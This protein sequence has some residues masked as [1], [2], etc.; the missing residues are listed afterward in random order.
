MTPAPRP[1]LDLSVSVAG[2]ELKN[3]VIAASGTF[4]Y[5]VEF[6]DIVALSRMGG[7]VVRELGWRRLLAIGKPRPKQFLKFDV[8]LSRRIGKFAKRRGMI[9]FDCVMFFHIVSVYSAFDSCRYVAGDFFGAGAVEGEVHAAEQ[10]VAA[11][12]ARK[13]GGALFGNQVLVP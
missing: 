7:F 4:G 10:R 9:R 11:P 6:E 1:A 2:I 13:L 12:G 5:G 3:P 8:L